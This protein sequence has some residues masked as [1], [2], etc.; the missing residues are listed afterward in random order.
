MIL[1]IPAILQLNLESLKN[2]AFTCDT[3]SI[4]VPCVYDQDVDKLFDQGLQKGTIF[5][6]KG[7]FTKEGMCKQ[8]GHG[9]ED[10]RVFKR[11][12][13]GGWVINEYFARQRVE[14]N[15]YFLCLGMGECMV[16]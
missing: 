5:L 12:E 14:R 16:W 10:L 6:V 11:Q 15:S 9:V 13:L 3:L 4:A 1:T 2:S 7:R 8:D